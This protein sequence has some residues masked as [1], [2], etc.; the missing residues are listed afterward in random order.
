MSYNAGDPMGV[1]PIK[2]SKY[3]KDW[4]QIYLG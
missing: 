4:T 2:N 1:I 3:C